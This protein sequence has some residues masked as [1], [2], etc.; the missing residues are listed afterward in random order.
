ME[1]RE[2]EKEEEEETEENE[3]GKKGKK[4]K[5]D[6]DV[7]E[8]VVGTEKCADVREVMK[9]AGKGKESLKS[10]A[11]KKLET[12]KKRHNLKGVKPVTR[13]KVCW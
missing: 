1:E 2:Q 11:R 12:C 10:E 9:G 7:P 5:T 8:N 6:G 3:K 13:K 4:K